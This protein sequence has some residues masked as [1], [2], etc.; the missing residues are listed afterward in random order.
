ML[1]EKFPPS[2]ND[3]RNHLKHKK[4]DFTLHDLI[5]RMQTEEANRL[6]DKQVHLNN[7]SINLVESSG[8]ARD[9]FKKGKSSQQDPQQK[10]AMA[11]KKSDN[12]I[13]KKTIACYCCGKLGH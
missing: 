8:S 12:K 9:R 2:W 11:P 10:K 6:K 3:F 1:L 13:Q 5:G 7:F 4:R